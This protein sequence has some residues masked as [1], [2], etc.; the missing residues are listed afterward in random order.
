MAVELIAGR[1]T[2]VRY[3]GTGEPALLLHCSLAHSGAWGGVMAGLVDRLS[4][5]AIDLPGHGATEFDPSMDIQD[6]ACEIVIAVLERMNAPAHLIGH[7]FGATV[8]MR[9][10]ITRPDLVTSLSI[11][12]PVYF[13]M[14]AKADPE[15]YVR[16]MKDSEAFGVHLL[17][18]NWRE[19]A[20]VFLDRWGGSV[21][22]N[23]MPEAQQNYMVKTIPMILQNNHSVIEDRVGPVSLENVSEISM[24][25]LLMEGAKSPETIC[26]L[27]NLL[28]NKL[29][30]VTRKVFQTAGHMGPV[31]HAPDVV[32]TIREFL[33]G[34]KA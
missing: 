25:C 10:A 6:Q 22:F 16:E 24:P 27:N 3:A 32:K 20:K 18:G 1:K 12:E 7:S 34:D 28:E 30:N 14:L 15:A 17:S 19:A 29:P 26:A 21:G 23:D 33:F 13:S 8:A 9:C 2:G 11:Y 31:N 5:V 4:M